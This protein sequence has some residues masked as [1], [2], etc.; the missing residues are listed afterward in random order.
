MFDEGRAIISQRNG[1]DS[2]RTYAAVRQPE[3]WTKDCGIDW[4]K[5][6]EARKQVL[7]V[8][9]GEYATPR[10]ANEQGG[11]RSGLLR[12]RM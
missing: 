10:E 4:S 6:D 1:N 11:E 7:Q 12:D 3:T 9:H 8:R 2:I 5:G